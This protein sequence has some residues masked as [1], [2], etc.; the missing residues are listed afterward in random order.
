[1]SRS[2][3]FHE[4]RLRTLA[5]TL[6]GLLT[7]VVA[8][9]AQRHW[10]ID[11]NTS[12]AWWQM[13][14]N[15]ND[16]WATT[17][18]KDPSWRPGEGRSGGWDINPKLKLARSGFASVPDTVHVPL[19]P[20]GTV[21]PV[22]APAIR[23][24]VVVADTL[25]WGGVRGTV[26]VR[27]DSLISGQAARDIAMHQV[28][29]TAQFPEMQFTLDSLVGLTTQADTLFGSAVGTF[30]LRGVPTPMTAVVKVFHDAGKMRVLAK[31]RVP[32]LTLLK[33]APRLEYISLANLRVW[34]DF[35][36]GADLVLRPVVMGAK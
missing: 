1:V 25:H 19:F 17:C 35:F 33:L 23:G 34:K 8:A 28:L 36:M 13:S 12:L 15:M 26:A 6:A 29:E 9:P 3:S 30:T 21:T 20:R 7:V 31:W 4:L 16:L 2:R 14:P 18:P 5:A 10:I 11:P 24:E 27:G 32:V 22:C